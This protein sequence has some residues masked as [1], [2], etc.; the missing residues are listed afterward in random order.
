[1]LIHAMIKWPDIIS[2][3]LLPF[4]LQLA[5]N[6]H[7]NTP[8]PFG[9]TPTEIFTGVKSHYNKLLDFHPF[10]CPFFVLDPTL[11]QGQ[12]LPCWKP[13][14][15]VGVYLGLSPN[16]ASSIP[17]VLSTTTG[18]VSP[19]FHI[20]YDDYF[21]AT[22]CLTMNTLPENWKHLLATSSIKYVDDD[23]EPQKFTT[24]SWYLNDV[25]TTPS[26]PLQESPS[27]S[28]LSQRELN[29]SKNPSST[30]Q[31][32]S[33]ASQRECPTIRPG[34][35]S[36]H[37]YETPFHKK[38]VAATVTSTDRNNPSTLF[39]PDLFAAFIAVQNSYPMH[40][41]TD[42]PFLEYISCAARMNPDVLHY[43]SMLRDPDRSSFETDMIREVNDLVLTTDTAE[44]T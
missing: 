12:K 25:D 5:I 40:S 43:G 2:K 3:N 20:V 33:S 14:S 13:R 1:M 42:L 9:L 31:R 17:L 39:D 16:H 18:L 30:S 6:L 27:D 21:T 19:Q 28:I 23:F 8:G 34:W 24:S 36:G 11:Q 26:P 35:N 10:G 29:V 4:A 37:K 32:E 38:Y 44:I 41:S 7:N 22:N 15:R